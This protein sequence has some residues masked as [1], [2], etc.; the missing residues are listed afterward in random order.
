MAAS[1]R[2]WPLI[3]A[4]AVG[5]GLALAPVAFQ[6]FTRAP[7]GADMINEFRPYMNIEKV[8]DF[9][10][11]LSLID[12]AN[13]EITTVLRPTLE[14]DGVD[15]ETTFPLAS[16]LNSEWDAINFDMSD[17]VD[18]M[19]S[20]IDNFAA[21]D[22]LPSFNLFPWFFVLPGFFIAVVAFLALRARKSGKDNR[23]LLIA[24]V[25]LGIAVVLAPAIFQMFTRAPKGGDM[26]NDFRPMMTTERVRNVQG[27]FI[28]LGAS[29]GEIRNKVVPA[30]TEASGLS[31]AEFA[32]T[33]PATVEYNENWPTIVTAFA[34]M[35]AAMA[36]NLDN[37]AAVDAMPPFA[38]FPWFFVIPGVL[39][40]GFGW[41]AL[42]SATYEDPDP[43]SSTD[44][45][46]GPDP[47][48]DPD[49]Q[50]ETVIHT[51]TVTQTETVIQ[52]R[53]RPTEGTQT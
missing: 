40:A 28:T 3:A 36:D 32:A 8:E 44:T 47:E 14:A 50:T 19:D 9:E 46:T 48:A 16:S 30:I 34:P 10:G 25:G 53:T 12:S 6:M 29:E 35:I 17:L 52:T 18:T 33:Y 38:L 49:S 5:V 13:A 43:D 22:A 7:M 20:N 39:V 23:R 45:E 1:K 15:Y 21:I 4:L 42:R 31:A 51:Q 41:V 26:I 2:S 27:Y 24:V 37:Y 11:Y